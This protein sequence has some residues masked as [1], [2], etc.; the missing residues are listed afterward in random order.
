MVYFIFCLKDSIFEN[1][2]INFHPTVICHTPDIKTLNVI[3]IAVGSFF[4]E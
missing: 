3:A 4:A 1:L 2:S